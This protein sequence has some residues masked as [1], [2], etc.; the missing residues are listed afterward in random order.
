M[1]WG[2]K[3]A[4]VIPC[5]NEE[6]TIGSVVTG[7]RSHVSAVIVV[8]DGSLDKTTEAAEAAGATVLCNQRNL[9]KGASLRVGWNHALQIGFSWALSLDGDGQHS[10]DDIPSF[11]DCAE[12]Q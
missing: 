7:A 8:N 9:G 5:F 11:F 10:P 2:S 12:R 1:N 4:A 6:A 3:C